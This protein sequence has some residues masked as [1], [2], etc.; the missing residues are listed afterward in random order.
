MKTLKVGIDDKDSIINALRAELQ[1]ERDA[2]MRLAEAKKGIEDQYNKDR[3]TWEEESEKLANELKSV[4][5][6][7]TLAIEGR[8]CFL[9]EVGS[10]GRLSET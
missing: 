1:S 4:K 7:Y 8:N 2:N 9:G 10:F 6:N 5:E 3:L